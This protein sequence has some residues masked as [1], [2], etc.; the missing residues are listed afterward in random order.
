M[1]TVE[2]RCR[3]QCLECTVCLVC[4]K[5]TRDRRLNSAFSLGA[6]RSRRS[7]V[8]S[9][10]SHARGGGPGRRRG[11]RRT[12]VRRVRG[13]AV[14]ARRAAR[15]RVPPAACAPRAR[16]CAPVLAS[17]PALQTAARVMHAGR[18]RT[19]VG[20]DTTAEAARRRKNDG[21]GAPLAP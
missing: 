3:V 20:A 6:R 18:H 14:A 9:G 16:A 5:P 17:G 12:G 11:T 4:K 7:T 1:H 15:P 2:C 19:S 13:G 10:D 8:A 21:T